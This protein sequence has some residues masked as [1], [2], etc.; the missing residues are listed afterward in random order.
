MKIKAIAFLIVSALFSINVHAL[1]V[2]GTEVPELSGLDQIVTDWMDKY[3]YKAA[4]IAVTK[5]KK[6]VYERGYGYQNKELTQPILPQAKMRQ[7]T[8]SVTF[9]RRAIRQLV[10]DGLLSYDDLIYQ[11]IDIEPWGGSYYDPRMFE[12]TVGDVVNDRSCFIDS[13]PHTRTIG[14]Q[15]NL[16]RFPTMA[17]SMS[18]MWA[19]ENTM[20][21]GCTPGQEQTIFSHFSM[22]VAALIIARTA[23]P[24]IFLGDPESVGRVLGEY[25]NEKIAQPLG[26]T[27]LQANNTPEEAHPDEIWY[28]SRFTCHPDWNRNW[29][30]GY[31]DISC[32]YACDFYQR[33]GSGTMVSSARDYL[34]YMN[35]YWVSGIHRSIN[36]S[37]S[38]G[39]GVYY[40]SLAGTTSV[41]LEKVWLDGEMLNFIVVANERNEAGGQD[42]SFNE[43]KD[44]VSDYLLAIQDWP[45]TLNM[46]DT[47]DCSEFQSTLEEHENSGRAY[48]ETETTG[49]TC[50]GAWC[51][52]GTT[53]TTW[54]ATGSGEE[55]GT[56]SSET[57]LLHERTP[58]E[59][60]LGACPGPDITPPVITLNGDN[61]IT[62]YK[63]SEFTDPGA[64]A[65]DNI[66]GDLTSQIT[67]DGYVD[68]NTIDSYALVY[69]V[70][71]AAGNT[72]NVRRTVN[73][74]A[75]PACEEF[76]ATVSNH[77]SADRAYSLT[78]TT[79]QTCYGSWCFGGTTTTTWY[80]QGSDENL[81]TDGSATVTLRTSENGYVTGSCPSEPVAPVIDSYE[82]S[83]LSYYKAVITGTA[84]DANGDIDHVTVTAN[85][86]EF[87]C[88][89]TTNFTC[90]LQYDVY[91]I[92][93]VGETHDVIL[94]A[95]DSRDVASDE[96]VVELTRP[97]QQASVAPEVTNVQQ[98]REGTIEVVTVNVSDVDGDL[99][100][101][102]L[103][104]M[105]Y[106]GGVGCTNT[107]GDQY[108][109]ELE[110][111]DREYGTSNWAIRAL[112]EAGNVTF[113]DTFPIVWEE[114]VETC[115]TASNSE[116]VNA[117]R[118]E[119]RYNILAYAI[120]SGDYLGMAGD[121]TSLEE[122]SPGHWEKVSSCE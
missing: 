111:S 118:A 9:T 74:V 33:P 40:G 108:R 10:E 24:G 84:S 102:V 28:E 48:S 52:G 79:G 56:N 2:T 53:T 66:D 58:G 116:H 22:E 16:G 83:S 113:S 42:N 26:A 17:E 105:D 3:G 64:T 32:A 67:I 30:A 31:D 93:E 35:N 15:M 109:C 51:F 121:T 4:T 12:I 36:Q 69:S 76:T 100:E 92:A 106:M 89:G 8:N 59:Y 99:E 49:Q 104:W 5:D 86:R 23:E 6:L 62:I 119:L 37:G 55:L 50:Y 71:D 81:G 38:Q 91:D 95:Y 65:T 18:Y 13:A 46:L 29:E 45:L 20:L 101:V 82:I 19:Y 98:T 1:P 57:L 54:Y 88:E 78:E 43:I 96:V 47:F 122:T 73:V 44:S 85:S 21:D 77:E 90:T 63:G 87:Y 61:P 97:E 115:F 117:D 11:V 34:I 27:V 107:G 39:H 110:L 41:V 103:Y 80:A 68:T 72:A 120:G 70:T 94:T 60:A 114:V 25:V 75:V 7:A 14:E 112:D